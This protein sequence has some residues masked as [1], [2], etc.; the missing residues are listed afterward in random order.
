MNHRERDGLHGTS[1]WSYEQCTFYVNAFDLLVFYCRNFC[2]RSKKS[3]TVDYSV[4]GGISCMQNSEWWTTQRPFIVKTVRVAHGKQ[5]TMQRRYK[6]SSRLHWQGS[7]H[8]D[9]SC[10]SIDRTRAMQRGNSYYDYNDDDNYNYN[11]D[12][13]NLQFTDP[14]GSHAWATAIDRWLTSLT[15]Q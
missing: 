12:E 10:M 5:D 1:C 9:Q 4:D 8:I 13:N 15:V 14:L 3:Q 2:N 11:S 7:H 6:D